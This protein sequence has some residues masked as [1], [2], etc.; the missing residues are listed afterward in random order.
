MAKF[1]FIAQ[2]DQ[3]DCGVAC[4]AMVLAHYGSQVPLHRLRR[5]SGTDKQGTSAYG[6]KIALEGY[7]FDC[8]AVEADNTVWQDPDMSFPAIAH[9]IKEGDQLHYLVVYGLEGDQLLIADPAEAKIQMSLADFASIWTGVL[10]IP[11]P[12]ENYQ[13]QVHKSKGLSQFFSLIMDN[14]ILLA[15]IILASIVVIAI[16]IGSSFYFQVL[17]D[18]LIPRNNY[19]WLNVFSLGLLAAYLA[20]VIFKYIRSKL[21]VILGQ[22]MSQTIMLDYFNHVLDL[23]LD[24]FTN[25]QAGDI[26]SRFL[27]ANKIVNALGSASITLVLDVG[28][29][30]IVGLTLAWQNGFLFLLTL[31]SLPFYFL[32]IYRFVKPLDQANREEMSS[33]SQLNAKIIEYLQGIESLKTNN[34]TTAAKQAVRFQ[35]LVTMRDALI[36]AVLEIKQESIKELV[37]LLTTSLTLWYGAYLVMQ[38][39]LTLGQ[40]IT[41]NALVVYFTGPLQN[42][43]KLQASLQEAGVANQRLNEVLEIDSEYASNQYGIYT[44]NLKKEISICQLSFAYNI[45]Q[46]TL[47]DINLTIPYGQKVA[48]VGPSGSGKSSLAKLLVALHRP[49]TGQICFED[50]AINDLKIQ[51]LRERIYYLPQDNFIIKGS[52]Y[53]N[54][55]LDQE[56]QISFGRIEYVM[57]Q[58]DLRDFA[59]SHSLGLDQP[60]EEGGQNLSGGQKQRIVLARALLRDA[61]IYILDEATSA[62]DPILEKQVVSYLLSL[63]KTIIFIAHHLP[64]VAQFDRVI[65]LDQGRIVGDGDQQ[66]LLQQ[67]ELYQA[68]Y[69][70]DQTG[71]DSDE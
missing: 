17:I 25:R 61:D 59:L 56:D 32:A 26:I 55:V 7:G 71:G 40:L 34:Y 20:M 24:F 36:T 64:L 39:Q 51:S 62:M 16:S 70:Q 19:H 18:Q 5:E 54:L 27:D 60:L 12:G 44:N 10:L 22:E 9:V 35:F 67:S 68:M 30:V 21:L 15:K 31:L 52:L 6:L 46:I 14:K 23:P 11:T 33:Q 2:Q 57:N 58:L 37:G 53:N 29:A 50:L 63:D 45:N 8:L 47:E 13:I 1:K 28:M 42:I 3:S 41:Y 49:Q 65:L 43:F 38:G 4:L 48:L 69:G 66:T